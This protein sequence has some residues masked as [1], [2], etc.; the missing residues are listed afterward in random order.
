MHSPVR[1]NVRCTF[2]V[3]YQMVI[4]GWSCFFLVSLTQRSVRKLLGQNTSVFW[5]QIEVSL[6]LL[7]RNLF[8][9]RN[10]GLLTVSLR[11]EEMFWKN[12]LKLQHVQYLAIWYCPKPFV[13]C[14]TVALFYH[15]FFVKKN[16]LSFIIFVELYRSS[17]WLSHGISVMFLH[18]F[19]VDT[20]LCCFL[21]S[22]QW[23]IM[24]LCGVS[25]IFR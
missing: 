8:W 20:P 5:C 13:L 25:Y 21:L 6:Y 24:I 23:S 10:L 19:E 17:L 2:R 7:N 22:H 16:H 15:T 18:R 14:L 9:E 11:F 12:I 4:S 3:Y 1:Y